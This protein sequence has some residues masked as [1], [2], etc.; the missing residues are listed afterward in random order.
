[1]YVT[2][3]LELVMGIGISTSNQINSSLN[4]SENNLRTTFER[5]ASGKR[6]NSAKDDA[7]AMAIVERFASQIIGSSQ[8]YRNVNDG[9]SLAQTADGY[10]GQI[11]DLMQRGRDLAMQSANGSLSDSDRA[12]LQTE[13]KNIQDEVARITDSAEFNGQKLMNQD[14]EMNFQVGPNAA[15]ADQ[16][17]VKTIDL[18]S[19]LSSF[20]SSDILSQSNA[21]AALS[22]TDESMQTVNTQRAEYGASMNRFES[23]SKNLLNTELNLEAAKSRMLDTDYA[24]TMS[25]HTKSLLLND[26]ATALHSQANFS[27][28]QILSLLGSGR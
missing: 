19:E 4:R 13:Y 14:A 7:A 21:Q 11:T 5:L 6:I 23:I 2:T 22:T 26:A 17:T 9:V 15:A 27:Q 28:Q 16:V 12:A 24:S 20:F 10:S 3:E 1:M 18:K 25:E 8:A